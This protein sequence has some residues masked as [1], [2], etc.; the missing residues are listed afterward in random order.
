M[1]RF[2]ML[3][4]SAVLVFGCNDG[5]DVSPEQAA[6]NLNQAKWANLGLSDYRF[7]VGRVCFCPVEEEIVVIVNNDEVSSAFFTPSG[8][9]LDNDRVA[10]TRT[11]DDYFALIQRG[12]DEE[13]ETLIVTY[14]PTYGFPESISIDE[15]FMIADEERSFRLRDFQ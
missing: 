7:T 3:L 9:M 2:L 6:L 8:Q 12:I 1:M 13:F 5:D 10:R 14:D 4:A 11:I 15:S